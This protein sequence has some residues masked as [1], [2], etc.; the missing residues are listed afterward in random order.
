MC[1]IVVINQVHI[2]CL[3]INFTAKVYLIIRKK[4]TKIYDKSRSYV[5]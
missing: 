2:K 1:S 5:D 3:L 4:K